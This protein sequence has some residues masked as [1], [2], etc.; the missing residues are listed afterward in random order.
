MDFFCHLLIDCMVRF[1][2]HSQIMVTKKVPA[3]EERDGVCVCHTPQSQAV[4][5]SVP[6][7]LKAHTQHL[8]RVPVV[9]VTHTELLNCM[10]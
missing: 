7:L 10:A 2:L 3:H 8:P 6:A 4:W 1:W 5:S 9:H